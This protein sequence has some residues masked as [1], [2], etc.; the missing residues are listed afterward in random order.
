MINF[1][2]FNGRFKVSVV[3]LRNVTADHMVSLCV[4]SPL[5]VTHVQWSF[6]KSNPSRSGGFVTCPH[7]ASAYWEAPHDRTMIQNHPFGTLGFDLVAS[8]S[9]S[10]FVMLHYT[11]ARI[12]VYIFC[13]VLIYFGWW[14]SHTYFYLSHIS[15]KFWPLNRMNWR[16]SNDKY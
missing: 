2:K 11:F 14:H 3:G 8:P 4:N 6:G 16:K 13:F 7:L 12:H 10:N 5:T 9:A 15:L 1:E